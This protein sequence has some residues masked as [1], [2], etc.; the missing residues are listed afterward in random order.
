MKMMGLSVFYCLWFD[1]VLLRLLFEEFVLK[2]FKEKLFL[3]GFIVG[4]DFRF[5]VDC[6]GDMELL[7]CLVLDFGFELSVI[8]LILD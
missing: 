8:E 3:V 6:L 5:G 4:Y 2:I 1:E 7:G